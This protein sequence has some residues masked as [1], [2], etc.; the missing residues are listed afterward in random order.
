MKNKL[1]IVFSLFFV[2]T[3]SHAAEYTFVNNNPKFLLQE[4]MNA[5][6]VASGFSIVSAFCADGR[7]C[8]VTLSD[9]KMPKSAK[10]KSAETFRTITSKATNRYNQTLAL[11]K[12]LNLGT[13]TQAEKNQLLSNLVYQVFG[14]E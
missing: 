7:E 5:D 10:S 13:A 2:V 4:R 11:V 12:K 9:V 1:L 8:T 6:L 3:T 14:A